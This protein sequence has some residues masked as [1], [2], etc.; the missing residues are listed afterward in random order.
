MEK[1]CGCRMVSEIEEPAPCFFGWRGGCEVLMSCAGKGTG[2]FV[3]L[4]LN[5]G[6]L[7]LYSSSVIPH[8]Y[9]TYVLNRLGL[10]FGALPKCTMAYS[11]V[12]PCDQ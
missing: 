2:I 5:S 7:G 11:I 4:S 10:L 9:I 12:C 3:P 6:L 8:D 1:G